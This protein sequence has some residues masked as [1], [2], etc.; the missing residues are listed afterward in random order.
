MKHASHTLQRIAFVKMMFRVAEDLSKRPEPIAATS[1]LLFHDAVEQLLKLAS[2]VLDVDAQ[3]VDF[4]KYWDILGKKLNAPLPQRATMSRLNKARVG[5]KHHG[6]FPVK[7]DIQDFRR[8]CQS[9]FQEATRQIF[10][11]SFDEVSLVQLLP[12]GNTRDLIMQA[13]RDLDAGAPKEALGNVAKALHLVE[14]QLRKSH[15]EPLPTGSMS[16]STFVNQAVHALDS[17][18][19]QLGMRITLMEHGI[20]VHQYRRIK[21]MMPHVTQSHSGKF[22]LRFAGPLAGREPDP[23]DVR[24]CIDFVVDAAVELMNIDDG[25]IV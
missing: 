15:L 4:M 10:E 11:L 13:E 24:E 8:S 3:N 2:E 5:L 16:R 21:A 22:Q 19:S 17:N 1:V 12:S 7:S 9:F 25:T 18:V 23:D 14:G 6:L 20:D